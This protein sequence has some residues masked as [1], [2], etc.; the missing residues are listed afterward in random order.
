[1][2]YLHKIETT[3]LA[4]QSMI[5]NQF[6]AKIMCIDKGDIVG[7]LFLD[8]RKAF[9]L[10]NHDILLTKLSTYKFGNSAL[11]LFTSYIQN[12]QQVMDSGKGLTQPA[13][14]KS[15]VP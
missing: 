8:F 7:T 9:D 11:K 14:I 1:M 3:G 15:G 4:T 10:V 2:Q 5:N 13:A 12:R 6:F